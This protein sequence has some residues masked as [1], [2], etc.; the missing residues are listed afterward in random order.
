MEAITSHPLASLAAFSA[1]ASYLNAK[2]GVAT[3]IRDI[4]YSL[5]FIRR[6]RQR[7]ARAKDT[8]S[9]Y[10]IF[11]QSGAK[12]EVDAVWFEGKTKSYGELKRE[13]D[14]FA[15]LLHARGIKAGDVVSVFTTNTP[16]M[17]VAILALSKLGA[18]A[19]LINTNLRNDTFA[20]ALD[21]AKSCHI[22]ST[23]DLA[24]HVHSQLPHIILDL[25]SIA[26]PVG[27][28][29][30][31][32][33]EL[34][35]LEDLGKASHVD[36]VPARRSLTDLAV[37]IYTS[38]T[39]GKPKACA[40]R[41]DLMWLTSTPYTV[42]IK[43]PAKYYPL[44][45]YS[46]LPLF[47]GT[48]FFG[49]LNYSLGSGGTICLAR[50]FSAS[51]F[52][53]EATECRANRILYVGELC[54]YLLAA[55]PSPYDRA[56]SV[57]HAYG[58]GLR[59]EI[60]DKFKERFGVE[61]IREFY[62]SSEGMA[63]FDNH[64]CAA[65][66]AGK[67]GFAGP[68]KRYMEDMTFIIKYD[69]ETR[70]PVRDPKTGFCIKTRLGEEGEIIGRI[71]DLNLLSRYLNDDEATEKKFLRNVFQKGDLFQRM[72]DLAVIEESGWVRFHDRVGDTFRW[73]GENVSTGEVRDHI[74]QIPNVMDAAVFGVK[75]ESYDGQAGGAVITLHSRTRATETEFI[76]SLYSVLV[77]RG[78]PPYALPR[79]VR[80]TNSIATG[81]TFK[82]AKTVVEKL[83][84]NPNTIM[85]PEAK[86]GSAGKDSR[87]AMEFD[88]LYWLNPA[89]GYERLDARTWNGIERGTVRL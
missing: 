81:V 34:V 46:P 84:W 25:S 87:D 16:E 26:L 7:T 21:V 10:E 13:V 17:V 85:P 51:N 71:R 40:I 68:I 24:E 35:V 65:A 36:L 44:R 47:H 53:R 14:Q 62:R 83:S 56:H 52:W 4:R 61:E 20:H 59:A 22:I 23:L 33:A 55:P 49:V 37:L 5:D 72:G 19:G 43:N 12:D 89:K 63:K 9:L 39:T 58:N 42:D 70:M 77:K 41:N 75:L 11:R 57:T 64:G 6:K 27:S 79:L 31:P 67:I 2:F 48:A 82:Q 78:V 74:C 8:H 86:P 73:K 54:R 29:I 80:M 50:K 1:V 76:S 69:P 18:V 66:G 28:K 45:T 60:W 88:T 15:G 32:N 38:G 3:D 30:P